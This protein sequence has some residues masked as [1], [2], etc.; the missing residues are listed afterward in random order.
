MEEI[1]KEVVWVID[2]V[3]TRIRFDTKY[4]LLTPVSGWFT[5]FEG[6]VATTEDNFN[7]SRAQLTIY[8]NSVYTGNEERDAHLRSPDFF[9]AA[10]HPVITWKSKAVTVRG[11]LI[12]ATGTLSIKGVEQEITLQARH[13]GSCPD[14]MGNT[15]AGFTLDATLNRKDFNITWN[16]YIDKHGL[17]LSDEVVLHCDVQLLKLP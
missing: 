5:Q 4:L 12:E 2:P 9:D 1:N 6:S 11:D 15:K 7:D 16:Q 17:L 13:V 8:T 10:R 3:H 14:P